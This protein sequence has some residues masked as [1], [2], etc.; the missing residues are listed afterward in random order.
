MKTKKLTRYF[1][2]LLFLLSFAA[3]SDQLTVG[4]ELPELTLPDQHENQHTVVDAKVVVFA[5]DK[6]A[7]ELAHQVLS[8]TDTDKLETKSIVYISDISGMPSFVTSMFALPKM[9]DYPYR[10]LLGYE[11]AD[12]AI[13]PR[14]EGQV[15]VL[16]VES[17]K[18]ERISFAESAQA[19]A[20]LIG[21]PVG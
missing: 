20:D 1:G 11:E 4:V 21:S 13:F 10:V 7:G 12:T 5:P 14:Q 3:V 15:T 6:D 9:R 17:G 2:V 18:L 19:L 16:Y 8:Q